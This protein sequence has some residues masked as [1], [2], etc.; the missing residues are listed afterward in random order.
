MRHLLVQQNLLPV[1]QGQVERLHPPGHLHARLRPQEPA[2]RV[3]LR[4]WRRVCLRLLV[5]P[6]LICFPLSKVG[7]VYAPPD[8]PPI[9]HPQAIFF[10]LLYTIAILKYK[11]K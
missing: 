3:P 4:R 2:L 7:P 9:P 5:P 1:Q 11:Y 10:I 8:C 6:P